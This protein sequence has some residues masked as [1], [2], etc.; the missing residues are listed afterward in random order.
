MR[1]REIKILLLI[2]LLFILFGDFEYSFCYFYNLTHLPCP[3]CGLT[4]GIR[5]LLEGE[6]VLALKYHLFSVFVF[7]G[8]FIVLLSF[9]FKKIDF[10]L[11]LFLINHHILLLFGILIIFYGILRILIFLFYSNLYEIF[12]VKIESKTW[13]DLYENLKNSF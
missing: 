8:I 10:I 13:K 7:L 12:F 9:I 1:L 2:Y 5:Y 6:W 3:G 11:E 4:R